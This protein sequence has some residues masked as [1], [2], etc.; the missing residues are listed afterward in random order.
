MRIV[1][2]YKNPSPGSGSGGSVQTG[3]AIWYGG[4]EDKF[5]RRC[6]SANSV[7]SFASTELPK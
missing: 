1:A 6:F 4:S 7:L 5:L 2:L 3:H